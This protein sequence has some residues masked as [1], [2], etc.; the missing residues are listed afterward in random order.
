MIETVET[1]YRHPGLA[2]MAPT[3]PKIGIMSS[4][5]SGMLALVLGA[6]AGSCGP[7]AP[8]PDPAPRFQSVQCYG[9][10]ACE[11][12]IRLTADP[13]HAATVE[14]IG[15]AER[16][17]GGR[18]ESVVGAR[19]AKEVAY[20]NTVI[21]TEWEGKTEKLMHLTYVT[22]DLRNLARTN[23]SVDDVLDA[24]GDG[25]HW[26]PAHDHTFSGY[27]AGRDTRFCDR[28]LAGDL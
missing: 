25:G 23:A 22:K 16:A 7:A 20:L 17:L 6:L 11:V 18:L 12:E 14:A 27:C 10:D 4:C 8:P 19:A 24:A 3:M 9:A 21:I 28:I 26:T 1:R 15:A 2:V 5:R 13:F